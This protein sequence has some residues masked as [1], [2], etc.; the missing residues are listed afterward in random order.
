VHRNGIAYGPQ[1]NGNM[2][3]V[4]PD[5]ESFSRELVDP[6]NGVGEGESRHSRFQ[7]EFKDYYR[8]HSTEKRSLSRGER[9]TVKQ[10]ERWD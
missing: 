8:K 9:E 10:Q 7:Q 1:Y 4:N 3:L 2:S 6:L 5:I